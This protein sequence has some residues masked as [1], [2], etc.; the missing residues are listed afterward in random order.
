MLDLGWQEFVMVGIVLVLV[1]G[2]KDMPRVLRAVAKYVG[3]ARGVAR[4]FQTSMMDVANQE[5]F[6]DVKNALQD[7]K[8][9]KIDALADF[10]DVKET[11][12]GAAQNMMA[13]GELKDSVNSIKQAADEFKGA[14]P[15]AKKAAKKT[16]SKVAKKTAPKKAAA[17]KSTKKK[18]TS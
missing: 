16:A 10:A 2:P 12:Q 7:V 15:A 6:R 14:E 9:G 8:T 4:D 1:V 11:A 17:K 13:D 18:A 5:E 3:K